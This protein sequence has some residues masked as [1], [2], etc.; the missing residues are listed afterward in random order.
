[1][2]AV[3]GGR[4]GRALD[5]ASRRWWRL[6]G[7]RV[8]LGGGHRWL[9]APVWGPGPAGAT[10]L[11]AGAG[12]L[13][14]LV[15]EVVPGGGLLSSVPVLDGAGFRA[16]GR[17][18]A[19]RDFCEH[20]ACWRME[21]WAQWPAL[22]WPGGELVGRLFGRRV[23]QLALPAR[24]P[25][26]ARGLDSRAVHLMEASGGRYA[27][28]WLR[29]RPA[30]GEF[31]CSGCYSARLLP[32]SGRP[33]VHVA[34]SLESGTVQV[35]LRPGGQAGGSLVLSSPWGVFGGGGA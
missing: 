12:R 25:G 9:D 7:R 4:L 6:A 33:P 28:G 20:A 23:R 2:A 8:D 5:M 10:W 35:F 32:G 15:R 29:A 13:G 17:D 16:A 27:A 3:T 21:A 31:V 1:M 24:P 14:G 19:V 26:V 30:A 34:F 22:S 11:R 18:R